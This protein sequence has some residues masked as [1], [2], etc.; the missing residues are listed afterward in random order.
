MRFAV[1]GPVAVVR[2][3][4]RHPV[5]RAQARGVLGLLVLDAGR[6]LSI[7]AI[8]RHLW[9][10]DPPRTARQQVQ[11]SVS[12]IRRHLVALGGPA[13]ISSGRFG[14]RLEAAP[15]QT[16]AGLFADAVRSARRLVADGDNEA[17]ARALRGGLD[18]WSG[19]PLADASGAFV[20]G[21]RRRLTSTKLAA[22]DLLAECELALSRPEAVIGELA[23]YV[24]AFPTEEALRA[25]LAVALYRC[26]RQV[27]ALATLRDYRQALAESEGMDPGGEL[28]ALEVAILRGDHWLTGPTQ[29]AAPA[30]PAGST[31]AVGPVPA[32]LPPAVKGFI[33]RADCLAAL[34]AAL[35]PDSTMGRLALVTGPA[36]VGKT[37]LAVHWGHGARALFPDGQLYVDL[38]GFTP[39]APPLEPVEAVGRFLRALG[40]PRDEVP[41]DLDQAVAATAR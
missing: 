25:R 29:A 40:T 23:P 39:D 19:E 8:V 22:L 28:A 26:G 33:G 7:A 35:T 41:T 30:R 32:L 18:L 21:M 37:A 13:S 3:G 15:E 10:G 31:R 34:T 24:A 11:A 12:A 14:Y 4:E 36:G 27:E 20:E 2:D 5:Y 1:L 38:R 6:P 16:D 17:A 9:A